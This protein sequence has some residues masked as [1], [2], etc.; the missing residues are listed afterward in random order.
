MLE[1][2]CQVAGTLGPQ[3]CFEVDNSGTGDA[4]DTDGGVGFQATVES[5]AA[6]QDTC[7]VAPIFELPTTVALLID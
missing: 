7:S 3:L 4:S 5:A 2:Q 1:N 6:L